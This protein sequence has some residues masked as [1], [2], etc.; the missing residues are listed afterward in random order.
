MYSAADGLAGNIIQ[1]I[2]QDADGFIW[3]L[4]DYQL[5]R[6]DGE[7]FVQF[8]HYRPEEPPG[9]LL[10]YQDS[11][12]VLVSSDLLQILNP[13]SGK[14]TT[15]DIPLPE[16]SGLLNSHIDATSTE[17]MIQDAF[18][19][20]QTNRIRRFTFGP[21]GFHIDQE[22]L[23]EFDP[24]CFYWLDDQGKFYVVNTRELKITQ[25]DATGRQ[26]RI[27]DLSD[28]GTLLYYQGQNL[29]SRRYFISLLMENDR[30]LR[31]L[32]TDPQTGST[33]PHPADRFFRDFDLTG[34]LRYSHQFE[35]GDV[36]FCGND[37]QLFHYNAQQ[38]T[39]F[40][41]R[42]QLL[43]LFPTINI[44][45][46]IFVDRSGVVWIASQLGLI[47]MNLNS[48]NFTHYLDEALPACGGLCS[49]R[50]IQEDEAGN[51]FV[52][53]YSGILRIDPQANSTKHFTN[54]DESYT[55]VPSG[56]GAYGN[57]IWNYDGRLFD[58]QTGRLRAVPGSQPL[59]SGEGSFVRDQHG[60]L[61][62][63]FNSQLSRLQERSVG[64]PVWEEVLTLPLSINYHSP[65]MAFG[66]YSGLLWLGL[67]NRLW[68]FDPNTSQLQERSLPASVPQGLNIFA[69]QE[70]ADGSLWLG[71]D[72]GLVQLMPGT[73]AFHHYTTKEGLPNNAVCGILPQADSCLWLSTYRG[74]TRFH[75]PSQTFINFFKEDGLSHNE[76][77]RKSYFK[78]ADGRMYFG[79]LNGVNAFYP[80]ELMAS[81]QQLNANAQVSLL[82][83][84]YTD[85][86]AD[87]LI[88]RSTV[89]PGER[90][91]LKHDQNSLTLEYL[92]TDY[93]YPQ[94]T[95]YA[96]QLEGYEATW[97]VPS[98][99]NF[100][101]YSNLPPGTYTFR[102]RA[103]DQQGS[104]H[105]KE[106]A[107]PIIILPPWWA[108][109]WAYATYLLLFLAALYL[110]FALLQRRLQLRAALAQ[111]QREAERLK[112]MDTFKSRL[113]TNLTHEFRTP[114]TV[115]LGMTEQIKKQPDQH[116]EQGTQLIE[117]NGKRLLRLINQMLDL[118]K[119]E[120]KALQLQ[121]QQ[122]DIIPYL[123]YLTQSFQTFAN[124][125]NLSLQFFTNSDQL[126]MDF[127]AEQLQQVITNLI[128][129][130]VKFTPSGGSIKVRVGEEEGQL[131]LTVSDTGVGIASADLPHIFSRFYQ[132]D[133]SSK[134]AHEGT[135]IG[136]AHTQELV[137]LMGGDIRVES[138][139]GKGST[140]ALRLPIKHTAPL[141]TAAPIDSVPEAELPLLA[142]E[143]TP[144]AAEATDLPQVL[145]IEDNPDVVSYLKTCLAGR[146]ALDIAFNG[147]I[148]TEKAL[149]NIPDLIIS[150]VMMPYKNGYEVCAELKADERTSHIPII[151]LTA[152]ADNESRMAGLRRGADVYLSK[153]FAQEELLVRLEQLLQ[154]QQ[155]LAAYFSGTVTDPPAE[156]A[157]EMEI[158]H[159]FV[160]KIRTIVAAHYQDEN[161]ALP[162]L[163][164]H[165]SMSRSQ[166]F[167][168][169]KALTGD[170]PSAFI[171]AYRLE[172][173][174]Y[175][176]KQTNLNVSEVAYRVG[177]KD[178]AHFSRSFS[179]AFG[180][181]PSEVGN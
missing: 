11:L 34:P 59:Q 79:G 85:A 75:L 77:N 1:N 89:R 155:R 179:Q 55:Y 119:L 113:Y 163:C 57:Q 142:S 90:V 154:R 61:W 73:S 68:Q 45:D 109:G 149:E 64:E 132:A 23:S 174:K 94:Q 156:V 10:V 178:V 58:P 20:P 111:E 159:A 93:R 47:K 99:Y 31:V 60:S 70:I 164:E 30:K 172:Q 115:M 101:R 125:H 143:E 162:N 88:R 140:F 124:K 18:V 181:P 107:L 17:E 173:A 76:F 127:D 167:R 62:R 65:A 137:K 63:M 52:S 46:K 106:L 104:W 130:A 129:N 138:E 122:A 147:Q 176:L 100:T 146:Y 43:E 80:D 120:N 116:L 168:K 53:Y 112:E 110:A 141:N 169:M 118:S 166:L 19:H 21:E 49:C 35:N 72:R 51:I 24:Y 56:L 50:S 180:F 126:V 33:D 36:L 3:V 135:G 161:F 121:L 5:H 117:Q 102:V 123:R 170:S 151:L 145:I 71:T 78:A 144:T 25:W 114:L 69:I 133:A 171:R 82:A 87:T 98:P 152:R 41:Y 139:P 131:H 4:C 157:A 39:L 44:L 97:S 84:E 66:Q 108:T 86:G 83:L 7:K 22:W 105:P 150:D 158:E 81:Y 40:D 27:V 175:L 134:R 103:R 16:G 48:S 177:Y 2:V 12:L 9:R 26:T 37:R 32:H 6:F 13:R 8:A 29:S 160:E 14:W 136:L 74:L 95:A 92:F 91:K 54:F 96:Y 15:H 42:P 28:W 128:S 148:G 67:N 165:L 153:P 38:D